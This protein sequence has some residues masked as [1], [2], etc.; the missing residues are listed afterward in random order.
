M[1]LFKRVKSNPNSDSVYS[2]P[3]LK[4]YKVAAP[5]I[6]ALQIT[7]RVEQQILPKHAM[8][9]ISNEADTP[10]AKMLKEAEFQVSLRSCSS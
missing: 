9:L 1:L 4:S 5:I 3:L 10:L 6:K 7:L 2:Q 8:Q